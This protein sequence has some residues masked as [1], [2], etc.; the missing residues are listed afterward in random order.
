MG[1]QSI[2]MGEAFGKGFQF[3][4]RK[5]SALTNDE[6]NKLSLAELWKDTSTD[7]SAMIPSLKAG[8]TESRELQSFIVKELIAVIKQLPQDILEGVGNVGQPNPTPNVPNNPIADPLLLTLNPLIIKALEILANTFKD[9]IKINLSGLT[10]EQI[11]GLPGAGAET[12]PSSGSGEQ[13]PFPQ[14]TPPAHGGTPPPDPIQEALD[15]Q[16]QSKAQKQSTHE[17]LWDAYHRNALTRTAN[18]VNNVTANFNPPARR[19]T[20]STDLQ[21]SND[22]TKRT[23]ELNKMITTLGRI[24]RDYANAN[25]IGQNKIIYDH[26]HNIYHNVSIKIAQH[27]KTYR[28]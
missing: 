3:G 12:P 1:A 18:V 22:N 27:Y 6:F 15:Q 11:S 24:K 9:G 23:L 20:Q 8:M 5:I 25:Q 13:E 19:R 10:P 17:A 4:K 16:A 21:V 26:Q 2:I 7:V 14:G 28:I